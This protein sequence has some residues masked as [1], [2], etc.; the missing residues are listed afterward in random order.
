MTYTYVIEIPVERGT[1]QISAQVTNIWKVITSQPFQF[2]SAYELAEHGIDLYQGERKLDAWDIVLQDNLLPD[3]PTLSFTSA[4]ELGGVIEAVIRERGRR[5]Y[6]FV[7]RWVNLSGGVY[8]YQCISEEENI[9]TTPFQSLQV[10][11]STTLEL[12]SRVAPQLY[13][14]GAGI[15]TGMVQA[16]QYDSIS[17][18]DIISQMLMQNKA[19]GNIRNGRLFIFPL[20]V[21]TETPSYHIKRG[22]M[23]VSWARDA[24]LYGKVRA[25]YTVRQYPI[26]ETVL[27]NHDAENWTGTVANVPYVATSL[28]PAPSG[29][30]ELLKVTTSASRASLSTNISLFDRIRFNWCPATATSLTITLLQDASNKL[31]Y[32]KSFAGGTGAGFIA[33][34]TSA[35]SIATK[36]I[37]VSGKYV[38]RVSGYTTKPCTYRISL[39]NTSAVVIW[40]GAWTATGEDN[41]VQADI[42][43]SIYETLLA[44]TV[45]LE[46]TALSVIGVSYGVQMTRCDI[47]IRL[48]VSVSTGSHSRVVSSKTYTGSFHQA[49][50]SSPTYLSLECNFGS[51]PDLGSGEWYQINAGNAHITYLVWAEGGGV[52]LREDSTD[53]SVGIVD[54]RL[55]G[56]WGTAISPTFQL[57]QVASAQIGTVSVTVSVLETTWDTVL[58]WQTSNLG[59]QSS[60]NLWES[61]DIPIAQMTKVGNPQNIT[62]L[63][64][65]AAG[66]NY[67]DAIYLVSSD[68]QTRSVEVGMGNKVYEVHEDLGSMESALAYARGFLPI[69][70]K[71]REQYTMDVGLAEEIAVGTTVD[72][73]GVNMTVYSCAY[74]QDGKTVSIGRQ[75]DTTKTL[76]RE[77]SR[78]IEALERQQ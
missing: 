66:D 57:G 23:K 62:S 42:P 71:A 15:L 47:Q 75:L 9:L 2:Q 11:Y 30:R 46:F 37:T 6:R 65:D 48:Q 67:L 39:L 5:V 64:I 49:A 41:L 20:Y 26:P 77:Q 35:D 58:V 32:T 56:T 45:R 69:I 70:S 38:T 7:I 19:Q 74:R 55:V 8:E 34:G 17:P 78:R 10:P 53:F 1:H 3:L 27:T 44:Q 31:T 22:D 43:P 13:P 28:L 21:S 60:F 52:V 59:W 18:L 36:D 14:V 29:A 24:E 33:S 40:Q 63:T 4:E 12:I 54:G 68:P 50:D 25:F 61:V 76:M 72:C 73:D 51:V 16:Q